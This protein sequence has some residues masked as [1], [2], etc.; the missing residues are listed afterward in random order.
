MPLKFLPILF[1]SNCLW[2]LICCRIKSIRI[3]SCIAQAVSVAKK[4]A[5]ICCIMD[6]KM[7]FIWKEVLL[8][9]PIRL[10][11]KIFLINSKGKILYLMTGWERRLAVKLSVIAISVESHVMNILIAKTIAVICFLFNAVSYTHLTLPTN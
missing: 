10:K 7:Y 11:K 8:I 6:L 9:M 4:P 3:L 1:V 2:L 5:L